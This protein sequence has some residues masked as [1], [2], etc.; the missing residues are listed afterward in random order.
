MLFDPINDQIIDDPAAFVQQ[1]RVLASAD[2][3]FV[4]VVC[5]H[6]VKPCVRAASIG[7][8]LSHVRNIENADVIPDALV[9]IYDTGVLHRHEPAAEGNDFRT[10]PRMLFVKWGGLLRG[11]AHAGKLGVDKK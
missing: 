7:D 6:G 2:I 5:E 3:E 11:F 9:F 8:Q 4:D 10:A 1:K